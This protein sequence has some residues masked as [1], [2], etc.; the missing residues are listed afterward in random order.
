MQHFYSSLL[1]LSLFTTGGV[2][3]AESSIES[4]KS[5]QYPK[6]FLQEYSTECMQTSVGEGLAEA[7]AKRLCECTIVKFQSQYELA[8]FKQLTI[9]SLNDQNAQNALVEV[10]QVCFEQI[11]YEQ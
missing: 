9:D 5:N 7:E 11:L 1:V 8:E 2:A 10:G 3:V 4:G 6:E